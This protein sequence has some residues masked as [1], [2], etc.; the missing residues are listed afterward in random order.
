MDSALLFSIVLLFTLSIIFVGISIAL[1][2]SPSR[3]SINTRKPL[4]VVCII[5]GLLVGSW[6]NI[7]DTERR[8]AELYR[9]AY[10][11]SLRP[12]LTPYI[13][14]TP[15]PTKESTPEPTLATRPRVV[16]PIPEPTPEPTATPQPVFQPL[17]LSPMSL[18][19]GVMRHYQATDYYNRNFKHTINNDQPIR[20]EESWVGNP[21]WFGYFYYRT[22]YSSNQPF[23]LL[24]GD[25]KWFYS[26]EVGL[27][28]QIVMHSPCPGGKP[29]MSGI[30]GEYSFS[31]PIGSGHGRVK[32]SDSATTSSAMLW[33]RNELYNCR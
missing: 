7:A 3:T 12:T 24:Q 28:H 18:E 31:R 6:T 2:K 10:L 15:E 16:N 22:I 5:L 32:L 19:L 25:E 13:P 26:K 11:D 17:S 33:V 30:P 9:N 21:D 20:I 14:P 29:I 27:R 23:M 8:N 1:G 4:G